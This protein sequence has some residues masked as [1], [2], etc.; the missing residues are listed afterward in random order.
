MNEV[1]L[2]NCAIKKNYHDFEPDMTRPLE[3][4]PTLTLTEYMELTGPMKGKW[5]FIQ[6]TKLI[7][8]LKGEDNGHLSPPRPYS[9]HTRSRRVPSYF[10][11]QDLLP[12]GEKEDTP[13][14]NTAECPDN[15]NRSG[16]LDQEK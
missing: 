16:K 12:C 1:C 6:Q 15:G 2:E 13:H 5:L 3:K 14:P 7:E 9:N 8:F 10:K 11:E 4:L